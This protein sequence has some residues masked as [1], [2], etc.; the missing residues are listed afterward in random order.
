MTGSDNPLVIRLSDKL[1]TVFEV[2]KHILGSSDEA[3]MSTS[4]PLTPEWLKI[5]SI[6]LSWI[7][8]TLFETLQARLIVEDPQTAKES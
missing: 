6:V 5:D 4:I 3:T 8:M 1:L 7:F 2:L